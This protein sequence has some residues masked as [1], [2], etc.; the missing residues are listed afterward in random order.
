MVTPC[1]CISSRNCSR[2]N[3]GIVTGG[4]YRFIRHPHYVF[5]LAHWWITLLPVCISVPLAPVFMAGWTGIYFLRAITEESDE[6]LLEL[7]EEALRAQIIPLFTKGCELE[8]AIA[9]NNLAIRYYEGRGVE[10]D[11]ARASKLFGDACG[12]GDARACSNAAVLR[13]TGEAGFVDLPGAALYLE[14][15]CNRDFGPAC[16]DLGVVFLNGKPQLNETYAHL[17]PGDGRVPRPRVPL[18]EAQYQA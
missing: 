1:L 7:V 11:A 2:S 9:C 10:K 14:I 3:R 13:R 17:M 5:K 8:S 18:T 15:G 16:T 6:T 12:A 4:P